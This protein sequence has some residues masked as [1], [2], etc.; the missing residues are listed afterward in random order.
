MMGFSTTRTNALIKL[1]FLYLH[2]HGND[3]PNLMTTNRCFSYF[4]RTATIATF[5]GKILFDTINFI[6]RQ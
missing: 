5:M 6:F 2:F 4:N 3:I 1:V